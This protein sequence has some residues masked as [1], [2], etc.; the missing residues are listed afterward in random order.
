LIGNSQ[1]R[2][3]AATAVATLT[4]WLCLFAHLGVLGLVGPDEPRYAAI[5][6]GMALG[7]DW[8]TPRLFGSP[9]FE[10]PVLY[11]WAAGACYKLFGGSELPAR[12]PSALAALGAALAIAWLGWKSKGQATG[13]RALLIFPVCVAGIGFSHSATPD[14]L[15]SGTLALAMVTGA[16]VLWRQCDLSFGCAGSERNRAAAGDIGGLAWFGIWLGLATL[17]KGPAALVLAGGSVGWWALAS[18]RWRGAMRLVHPAAVATWGVVALPWYIV[19]ALRNP[20]FLR[21]FILQHNFERY[22]TPMFQHPQPF[23]FFVLMALLGLFP[24]TPLLVWSAADGLRQIRQVAF[25]DWRD[26]IG[27]YLACWGL[28]PLLFFSASE[29]KLPGYVLPA[30][31]PLALLAAMALSDERGEEAKGWWRIASVGV[32][33]MATATLLPAWLERARLPAEAS[34]W[35][36]PMVSHFGVG[37]VLAGAAVVLLAWRKLNG[38]AFAVMCLTVALVIVAIN[39]RV[40][41]KVNRYVSART[42]AASADSALGD[43]ELPIE[44]YGLRRDWAYQL[45]FYLGRE[46]QEWDGHT[47]PMKGVLLFTNRDG[48][49]RLRAAV[50]QVS[51]VDENSPEAILVRVGEP[52]SREQAATEP[53]DRR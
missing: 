14:M 26:G 16:R 46:L 31:P 48:V 47:L 40:L 7:G 3:V 53:E 33:W 32:L 1:I 35:F 21:T 42:V 44:I 38:E 23:W 51:V 13:Y 22:L 11:Y 10:K 19:C 29:S 50:G 24:W 45:N 30:M 15:F 17:T 41:T 34:A 25:G 49:A 18:G 39:S 52:S 9:W 4:L 27:V 8:V 36:G 43:S 12:I 2:I 6:R 28:F 37:A 20:T 5:A